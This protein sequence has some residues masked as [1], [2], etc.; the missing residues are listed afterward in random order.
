RPGSRSRRF[1]EDQLQYLDQQLAQVEADLQ[2][3]LDEDADLHQQCRLLTSIIGIGQTSALQVLTELPDLARF[4]SAD[5][6]VAYAGL[7]PHQQQSGS[8][9]RRSWLSKQGSP[10]LRKALY[11]PA[12]S[13]KQH[14]PQLRRFA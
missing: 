10:H 9:F 14:N 5:E 7:C 6:L 1:L 3:Q 12:L 13:A 8:Q 4:H 11:F 2:K